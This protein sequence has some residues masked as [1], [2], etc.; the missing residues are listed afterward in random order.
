MHT[1]SGIGQA[2]SIVE[3][4]GT[5]YVG[6]AIDYEARNAYTF[7]V[8]VSDDGAPTPRSASIVVSIQVQDVNEPP[9]CFDTILR[10]DENSKKGTFVE[11][12]VNATDP[13]MSD[14]R[15]LS[16]SVEDSAYSSVRASSYEL[17][18][19]LTGSSIE[20]PFAFTGNG[21]LVVSGALDFEGIAEEYQLTATVTDKAGLSSTC[22]ITV[23]INDMNEPPAYEQGAA[24]TVLENSPEGTP[25]TG[26]SLSRLGS[27]R[28]RL[29]PVKVQHCFQCRYHPISAY[30]GYLHDYGRDSYSGRC[31]HRQSSTF[32]PVRYVASER[33]SL[34][35]SV[36]FRRRIGSWRVHTGELAHLHGGRSALCRGTYLHPVSN[37]RQRCMDRF[38]GS[39]RFA[40]DIC[41]SNSASSRV[42]TVLVLRQGRSS[43]VL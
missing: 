37:G 2:L 14:M 11:G 15:Q 41:L 35:Q 1:G 10:V 32:P 33:Q 40:P 5:L 30:C 27:R 43:K 34:V 23:L 12:T 13:D 39:G 31:R 17:S 16:Y 4:D 20:L 7:E 36:Y 29:W 18:V 6:D 9:M 3:C 26:E 19:L 8:K 24:F 22:D 25:L 38:P 42:E 28:R 21:R